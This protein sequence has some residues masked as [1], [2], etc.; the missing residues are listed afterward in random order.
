MIKLDQCDPLCIY[1]TLR[2]V[3]S[4]GQFYNVTPVLTFDQPLYWKALTI[5]QSQPNGTELNQI[6]L[7]LGGI[8]Y[9]NEFLGKHRPLNGRLRSS[10]TTRKLCMLE[11]HVVTHMMTGEAVSRAI[12]GHL[13]P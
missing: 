7:R 12:R 9:A 4:Q 10:R 13:S 2:F 1:S 5:I 3:V 11:T 6:V 8:P